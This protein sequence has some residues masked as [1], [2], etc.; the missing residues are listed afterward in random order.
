M[1]VL[2]MVAAVSWRCKGRLEAT[3]CITAELEATP[4]A[5]KGLRIV[6]NE[7]EIWIFTYMKIYS[8]KN[9]YIFSGFQNL[10]VFL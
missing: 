6:Y 1:A 2:L 10:F 8:K 3:M 9:S 5:E 7:W 4:S